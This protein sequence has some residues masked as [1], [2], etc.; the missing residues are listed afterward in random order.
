MFKSMRRLF[1]GLILLLAFGAAQAQLVPEGMVISGEASN[2]TVSVAAPADSVEPPF[3]GETQDPVINWNEAQTSPVDSLNIYMK[4][5][6][7]N[8]QKAS[9]FKRYS[10]IAMWTS[11]GL[12]ALGAGMLA[13]GLG[14]VGSHDL[15]TKGGYGALGAGFAASIFQF[16]F[17]TVGRSY[18]VWANSYKQQMYDYQKRHSV[19]ESSGGN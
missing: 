9:D 14:G 8:A 19:L 6:Q 3:V 13:A 11:F 1:W 5:Y 16:S 17:G 4:G 18:G 7:Y 12:Y 10:S 2:E 15:L